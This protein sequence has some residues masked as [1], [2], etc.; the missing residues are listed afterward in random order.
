[1]QNGKTFLTSS[2]PSE[3]ITAWFI[4]LA[5]ASYPGIG[6]Q[7]STTTA[8]TRTRSFVCFI[9]YSRLCSTTFLTA[10]G[11]KCCRTSEDTHPG[12][13]TDGFLQWWKVACI[14]EPTFGLVQ[15]AL[16]IRL[17]LPSCSPEFKPWSHHLHFLEMQLIY[18]TDVII[19]NLIATRKIYIFAKG[20]VWHK[21]GF[22]LFSA[23]NLVLS[24]PLRVH[25]KL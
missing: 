10:R 11:S 1:M 21:I 20:Q 14:G 3:Q 25:S 9:W 18:S 16:W 2:N 17:R 19:C 13:D 12:Q 4:F 8:T 7:F 23:L 15:I 24:L 22:Q 6:K 5:G